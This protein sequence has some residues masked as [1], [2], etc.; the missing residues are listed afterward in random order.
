M[1][2]SVI[3]KMFVFHVKNMQFPGSGV[4]EIL[5]YDQKNLRG[6]A[7]DIKYDLFQDVLVKLPNV[8]ANAEYFKQTYPVN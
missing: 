1:F 8:L 3:D 7:M 4:I 2:F 5:S 6:F